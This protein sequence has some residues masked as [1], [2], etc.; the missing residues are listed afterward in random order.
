MESLNRVCAADFAEL[1][2][3]FLPTLTLGAL[4]SSFRLREEVFGFA[5]LFAEDFI[6]H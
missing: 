5:E 4:Y 3:S 1:D 6:V 2:F